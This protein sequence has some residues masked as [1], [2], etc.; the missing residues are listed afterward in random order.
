[1]I[2]LLLLLACRKPEPP[3]PIYYGPEIGPP[4]APL[5]AVGTGYWT[6]GELEAEVPE[7]W[8]GAQGRPGEGLR[9]RLFHDA[10]GAEL[11]VWRNDL[12]SHPG[13]HRELVDSGSYRSV[14]LLYP[15]ATTTC[16]REVTDGAEIVQTWSGSVGDHLL[17]V[18]VVLPPGRAFEARVALDPFFASLRL[19]RRPASA[20][21][22]P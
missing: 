11:E 13:C 16:V 7:G 14:P 9:L 3:A 1:M 22:G 19:A 18:V 5:T 20:E 6:D 4:E 17:H 21:A 2:A 10:T 8:H 15:A 12:P